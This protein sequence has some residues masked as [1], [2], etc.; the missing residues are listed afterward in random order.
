MSRRRAGLAALDG[1]LITAAVVS[2]G[3]ITG[4]FT[5]PVKGYDGWGHLTK[6]VLILRDFPAIDWNYDW[7]SGSP[8][9]LGGYPPLFYLA[10]SGLAWVGVD[11]MVVMNVLIGLSYV[12]MTLSL[13]ALARIVTDSRIAGL[14]AAGVLL[15]TPAVWTPYVQAG[16]YTRVFGMAFVSIAFALMALYLRRPS[17]ARY[18]WCLLAVWGALNSHVVL[19]A[20]AVFALALVL[21]LSPD[22]EGR[23]RIWRLGLLVPPVLLSAY[24]YLPLAL[25]STGAAVSAS[26][27]P[28]EL[29]S[30]GTIF[31]VFIVGA[32]VVGWLRFPSG[33]RTAAP[34]LMLVCGIVC[35][36]CLVYAL[37][38]VPRV[39]GLLPQ[40]MLFF[41]SWFLAAIAGL[42]SGS[43][44]VPTIAWQR[45]FVGTVILAATLISILA[46]IPLITQTMVRDPTRPETAQS[47][48]QPPGPT[49]NNFRVASPSDNLSVWFNA[50][51]AVPQTRGYAAGP[52]ILNPDWQY[53]L[54]TTGWSSHAAEAQRTFLFDWYGARW[55]YV[56]AP[57]IPSTAGVVPALMSHPDLYR[58]LSSAQSGPSL[59]FEYLHP[60]PIAAATNAP[61]ILVIGNSLEYR[62]V[63]RDLSYSGFDTAH[64]IPVE[65]GP[66]VDDFSAEELAQFDEVVLYGG[67]AR[68]TTRAANLLSAYVRAGGGLVVEGGEASL[69]AGM[70]GPFPVTATASAQVTGE[71]GFRAETSPIT[72]GID[73]SAFG[74]PSNNGGPWTVSVAKG[75]PSWAHTVL[76]SRP[77]AVVVTGQLG[78]GRVVWSGLNLPYH[79]DAYRNGEESRFLTNAIAWASRSTPQQGAR[80][81]AHFDG[82]QQTTVAVDATSRGVLFKESFFDR[83][84]AYVDGR[85]VTVYRAGPG[86]MLVFLPPGTRFPA[87]V[88]L[89]YEKSALDW[90]GIAVSALTLVAL[91]T[92][93]G[94]RG[95]A[96]RSV[97]VWWSRR[98]KQWVEQDG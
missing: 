70:Q 45:G 50:V 12:A 7:Y 1:A 31:P 28:L 35:A 44:R 82:P 73:F 57:Y 52:Q 53:W 87:T 55:V 92:W 86:F 16:L 22:G 79:V 18:L 33:G 36:A 49:D 54:D 4:A 9:F 63:F 39:A 97:Q 17:T 41:L 60:T 51:Y 20:L 32:S 26:Y 23:T 90:A 84:H 69:A 85:E 2:V 61:V 98:T 76:G 67:R 94:W 8:F 77:G 43:V 21:V 88:T 62:I 10:A 27:P 58:Q 37:A 80:S 48:W 56:P 30:L 59:T 25:Y 11:H 81:T 29:G 95:Q 83:W 40:N 75:V 3:L 46:V 96:R 71:W 47:G 91:A 5:G 38:P 64:V 42:A 15:A 13:Y 19:G 72:D 89:R 65:G 68:D 14:V 6:V 93:P 24:Y 78:S 66:Y 74:P 34:R